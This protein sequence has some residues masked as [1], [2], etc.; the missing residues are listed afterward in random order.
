MDVSTGAVETG[1]EVRIVWAG[2]RWAGLCIRVG[3]ASP[4]QGV[5][6]E[7]MCEVL[8]KIW[9]ALLPA[10]GRVVRKRGARGVGARRVHTAA[11]AV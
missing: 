7:A 8:E 5:R 3:A 1:E 4:A 6:V 2:G 9:A 10:S 11:V